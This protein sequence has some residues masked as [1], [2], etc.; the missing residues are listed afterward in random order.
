MLCRSLLHS[1][2]ALAAQYDWCHV[3]ERLV[4]PSQ[5]FHVNLH[6][7]LSESLTEAMCA[8]IQPETGD[9]DVAGG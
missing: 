2:P 4:I 6:A 3:F 5:S 1:G 7:M 9:R 8:F